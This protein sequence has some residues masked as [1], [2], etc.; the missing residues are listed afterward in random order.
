MAHIT[1]GMISSVGALEKFDFPTLDG[2][3][4]GIAHAAD[5]EAEVILVEPFFS[6]NLEPYNRL[7]IIM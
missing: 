4:Q 7:R 6:E 3:H 1:N 2:T 5:A